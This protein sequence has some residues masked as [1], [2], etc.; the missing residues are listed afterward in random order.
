MTAD[1]GSRRRTAV[2]AALVAACLTA[3]FPAAGQSEAPKAPP[4]AAKPGDKAG[5][6]PPARR[7]RAPQRKS[8]EER[9]R[10]DVPVAFPVDI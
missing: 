9:P 8:D 7:A 10:P 2:L 6:P 1:R 4:V 3:P 5:E